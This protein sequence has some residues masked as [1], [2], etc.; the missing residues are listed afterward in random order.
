MKRPVSTVHDIILG[1][2]AVTPR[3]AL[4]LER[5]MEIPAHVW[6]RLETDYRIDKERQK[7]RQKER[8]EFA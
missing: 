7:A 3:T 1:K 5:A 4:D 2:K 6:M 8:E